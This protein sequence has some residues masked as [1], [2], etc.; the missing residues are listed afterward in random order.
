M[1]ILWASPNVLLDTSNGA[2]M[3]VR[4][5]LRQLAQR[6]WGVLILGGTVFVNTE[7]MAGRKDL[8]STL[9]RHKGQFVDIQDGVLSHRVLVT[10]RP[11]RRLLFSYE[12]KR[13]FDEYRRLLDDEQ[14][15]LV[16]FFDNSLIT[17][18]T[19]DEARRRHIPVG[20]FL[21]H[22]NNQGQHWCR[23]VDWM[24]TDTRATAQMY[25]KREGYRMLP[26]G[27]FVNPEDVRAEACQ[28]E[29]LLFINP[30][31]GKGGVLVAQIALWLAQQRP[32]IKLEVV[33]S[34]KTWQQLLVQVSEALGARCN[35]LE[36]V[37]VTSNTV[38]MRP[39]YGRA[40]LLLVPSIWWESGP[41]V[42]VEAL[43]NGIPVIGSDSGGI[44]EV[45]GSGGEII[46][47]PEHYRQAPYTRLL[48]RDVVEAFAA[49]ICR[50]WD[51]EQFYQKA[52]EQALEA[53]TK[54]HDL[55]RNGDALMALIEGCIRQG[56]SGACA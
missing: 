21:M 19:A 2:A 14:P 50:Y 54:M 10:E 30:I 17:L 6:G 25:L 28:R 40:R 15:D 27:S 24:F 5:C 36:N 35:A 26:V 56:K 23:D 20:V 1:K 22:G 39:V 29:N 8:W 37:R 52:S 32:D 7:G 13:W 46:S 45:L 3:M 53:H 33:D 41:R 18:L 4:E 12:E 38:D 43:I 55:E 31:P 44:P 47:I 48:S 42:I 9:Q 34:R 49:R 51:D 11:Q 16:L